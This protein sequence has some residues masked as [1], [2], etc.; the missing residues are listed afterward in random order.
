MFGGDPGV[1]GDEPALADA[2]HADEG[3]ELR[4]PLLLDPSQSLEEEVELPPSP[5]EPCAPALG[6]VVARGLAKAPDDRQQSAGELARA[7][8]AALEGWRTT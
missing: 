4:R 5:D 3:D 7:E 2:R 1:L 8:R 6:D